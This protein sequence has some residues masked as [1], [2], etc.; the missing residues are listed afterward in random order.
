MKVLLIS[1]L[2]LISVQ[3][4]AHNRTIVCKDLI[5]LEELIRF[6]SEQQSASYKN[7]DLQLD[8]TVLGDDV[9][10]MKIMSLANNLSVNSERTQ[11]LL[12]TTFASADLPEVKSVVG[13]HRGLAQ[14][15]LKNADGRV[16]ALVISYERKGESRMEVKLQDGD[17]V[18]HILCESMR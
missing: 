7:V 18:K 3:T 11:E 8:V 5:G 12:T 16:R 9:R 15:S 10:S 17:E 2:A 14:T 4:Y 1:A 13:T 6:P